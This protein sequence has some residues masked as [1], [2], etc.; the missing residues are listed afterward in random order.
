MSILIGQASARLGRV[1]ADFGLVA[2][3]RRVNAM[4]ARQRSRRALGRLTLQQ[5]EDI[6]LSQEQALAEAA[7]PWWV[8]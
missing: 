8:R 2:L 3:T 6:G 7:K 4:L 1:N 5:L